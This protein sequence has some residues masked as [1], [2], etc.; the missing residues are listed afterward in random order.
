[1]ARKDLNCVEASSNKVDSNLLKSL[2][3]GIDWGHDN[4]KRDFLG[5]NTVQKNLFK[6][7]L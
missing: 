4:N 7:I 1:M 3:L 6:N 5:R 2:Y